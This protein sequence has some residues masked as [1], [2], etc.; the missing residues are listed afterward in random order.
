MASTEETIVPDSHSRTYIMAG[1]M[2]AMGLAAMDGTIVATAIPSIVHDLGGF[3]LFPWVFSVYLLVQAALIPI[4]GKLAD[5]YGRKPMLMIG[6][7]IFLV[8]SMLSGLSW[9]M[10][11]LIIFRGLQGVGAAAIIPIAITVVGDLFSLQERARMQGYLSSVWGISAVVGPAIGGFLVQY[12]SWHWVFYINVPIG[13]A[14][15][16]VIGYLFHEKVTPRRHSIDYWG[17]ILL[18]TSMG[19][20]ILGLL[21]GG[22]DWPWMSWQSAVTLGG[23]LLLVL[24]LILVESRAKEPI[25]PLWVF[26][27]RVLAIANVSSLIIGVLS[28]GLSSFLPTYVQGVLRQTP[29]IA[30]F[31]LATMSIGWPVASAFSGKL[32][33]R[34]GFR[35][36][37]LI[38]AVLVALAGWRFSAL[39]M[40]S[41]VILVAILSLV[42]GAGLGLLST[43]MVVSI[44]SIVGWNHRG[45]VTGS[46]MFSRMLGSTL[47]VAVFGSLVN[48]ALIGWFKH[49]PAAIRSLLPKGLNASSIISGTSTAAI[50]ARALHYVEKGLYLGIHRIFFGLLI[51]GILVTIVGLFFPRKPEPLQDLA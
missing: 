14:A 3:S 9:N 4:Y 38:G 49:T 10:V 24:G 20:L 44:Q 27:R 19:G 29:L 47:G 34:I 31:S 46:N 35:N 5:V 37:G 45:V 28:M 39:G 43:S 16:L 51:A 6:S 22:V 8:G 40:H 2:L 23:G 25:I 21:E 12:A 13:V 15:L 50:P 32:Y 11:A 48:A 7:I 18:M 41:S 1:L 42:M 17:S 33:L 36:T 30:G 26:G